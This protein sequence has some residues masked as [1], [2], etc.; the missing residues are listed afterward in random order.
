MFFFVVVFVVV[1]V[2]FVVVFAVGKG[3]ILWNVQYNLTI[4]NSYRMLVLMVRIRDT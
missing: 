2:V 1:V 4:G 3:K